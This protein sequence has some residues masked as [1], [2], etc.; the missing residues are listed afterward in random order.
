MQLWAMGSD[1]LLP[2]LVRQGA[3]TLE[4]CQPAQRCPRVY[5]AVSGDVSGRQIAVLLA[6]VSRDPGGCRHMPCV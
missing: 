3:P 6:P 5:L 4:L 1:L 2:N